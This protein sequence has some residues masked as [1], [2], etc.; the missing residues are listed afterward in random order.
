M[1]DV[2]CVLEKYKLDNEQIVTRKNKQLQEATKKAERA[3]EAVS[4][5]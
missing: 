2:E 1:K 4:N 3:T 5:S